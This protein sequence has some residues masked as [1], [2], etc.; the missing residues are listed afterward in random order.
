LTNNNVAGT[1]SDLYLGIRCFAVDTITSFCFAKSLD[2][3][4]EPDFKAPIV[5]AMEA[6]LPAMIFFKHFGLIRKILF[7]LPPWLTVKFIPQTEGLIKFQKMLRAQIKEVRENP[8]ALEDAPHPIIYHELLSTEL[9]KGEKVPSASSLYEEAQSLT[10]KGVDA[11]SNTIM[12]GT[13]HLL[14]QP[15]LVH[16]LKKELLSAWPVLEKAPRYE[17]LEKL[18]FLV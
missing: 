3:L 5:E 16:R 8:E 9:G 7:S 10:F 2:A 18:P 6:S 11:A 13:W 15:A 12:L 14:D 4:G 1:S 17:A